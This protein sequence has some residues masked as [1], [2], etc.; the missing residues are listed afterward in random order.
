VSGSTTPVAG[1][2]VS[3][4]ASATVRGSLR[5]HVTCTA[6]ASAIHEEA[7]QGALEALG[8]T[9]HCSNG[10]VSSSLVGSIDAITVPVMTHAKSGT[11]VEE[12]RKNAAGKMVVVTQ[13]KWAGGIR[14]SEPSRHL[15]V[16]LTPG[17]ATINRNLV[18]SGTASGVVTT[19]VSAGKAHAVQTVKR[20]Y[21]LTWTFKPTVSP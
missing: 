1:S 21:S 4:A 14:F 10:K 15:T 11:L 20:G 2:V 12:K 16:T 7:K 18:L 13:T 3:Y 8:F 9:L 5:Q 17:T 19:K 6:P